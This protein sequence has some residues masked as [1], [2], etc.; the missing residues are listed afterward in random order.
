M[1][2]VIATGWN[3]NFLYNEGLSGDK[4]TVYC[5]LEVACDQDTGIETKVFHPSE[6]YFHTNMYVYF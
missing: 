1:F 6:V 4:K 3:F 5:V 2:S